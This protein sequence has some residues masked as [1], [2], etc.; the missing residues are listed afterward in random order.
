MGAIKGKYP[1]FVMIGMNEFKMAG[2]KETPKKWYLLDG[3][4][5]VWAVLVIALLIFVA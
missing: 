1:D 2:I 5:S 4:M 3:A